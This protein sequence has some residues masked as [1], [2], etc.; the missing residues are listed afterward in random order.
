SPAEA[1]P[2]PAKPLNISLPLSARLRV[3]AGVLSHHQTGG[4]WMRRREWDAGSAS[5]ARPS[6]EER[7]IVST[8]LSFRV[9]TA[10]TLVLSAL[11]FTALGA[12]ASPAARSSL[13]S[14][15]W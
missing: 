1:Q 13:R 12:S 10:V 15:A 11:T 7:P 14:P 2:T 8:R 6:N 5:G 4:Q 3:T 9:V